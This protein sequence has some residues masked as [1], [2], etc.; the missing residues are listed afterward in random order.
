M[1]KPKLSIITINFN[2]VK[3]LIATLKS[4]KQQLFSSYEHIIIDGNSTD[5]SKEEIFK[6]S[7]ENVHLTYWVSE[8]DN[9]VYNAMNKGII[10]SKGEYL[11]FLNS[12]DYLEP[13]TLNQVSQ[14][15]TG[16]DIIYGDLY[17]LPAKGE[18]RLQ[19]FA[20]PPFTA[21]QI[22]SPNFY[23]PHPA[24]FIKREL[25]AEEKYS[26]HYKIVSDWEFWIKNLLF[27]NCTIKH[28][29]IPISN[30]EDAGL[31]SNQYLMNQ[32]RED[33]LSKL[34]SPKILESL[35]E[36]DRIKQSPLYEVILQIDHTKRFQRK[37]K[38]LVLFCYR[39]RCFF[40]H[41]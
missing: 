11:L 40:R 20:N 14:Q 5:G 18:K 41:Q 15:L 7:K 16:E 25:F 34:C 31:S 28:L 4:I 37:M 38:K 8:K 23:L 19:S 22:I 13:G 12:G 17:F 21:S 2:N 3:G 29:A 1:N 24:S 33:A 27:K 36:L 9:G 39:I 35:K 6:Y 10:Q 32:E 26:E 30:F